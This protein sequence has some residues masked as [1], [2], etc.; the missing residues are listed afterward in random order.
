MATVGMIQ[1]VARRVPSSSSTTKISPTIQ[2]VW[3][4]M[5]ARSPK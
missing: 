4:G 1:P 5:V 2:S 3:V